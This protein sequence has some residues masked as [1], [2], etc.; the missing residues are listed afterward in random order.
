MIHIS[1]IRFKNYKSF[2]RYTITL[3]KFNV[4]VGPNNSGKSTIIGSLKI[5]S[6]GIRKAKSRTPIKIKGPEGIDTLGYEIDLKNV[7]V[8]TENIFYNYDDS[9]PAIITFNLSN[10]NYLKLF[11]F[12]P[13]FCY[14]V[15]ETSQAII[16]GPSDF[17]RHFDIEIGYVP[18]LGPVEHK[19]RKFLKEAARLALLSYTASRNFRNIWFH[20]P[21]N[22]Q[23]FRNLVQETWPGMDILPPEEDFSQEHTTLNMFCPEERIPREIF[24]AGFGFQVWCQMLT[25][26]IQSR[27]A[28]I[29]LIDEPD[30]YLHSDLQRQLIGILKSLG[31]DILIATHSTEMISEADINEV[32]VINKNLTSAQRIKNIAQLQGI[33]NILGSNLNPILTQIAKTKKVLFVEGKD[34]SIIAKIARKLGYERVATRSSFAVVPVEGFNPQRLYAFKQGIESTIGTAIV[35]GVIFDRDYR[36]EDEVGDELAQLEEVNDFAHIH[37]SKELEN[38]LLI[39]A[40]IQKAIQYKTVEI[41]NRINKKI[42]FSEDVNDL[43]DRISGDLKNKTFSQLQAKQYD[44]L[45]KKN[46][47][48][49]SST[50]TEQILNRF[51]QNWQN[52]KTRIKILP[53]KEVLS[54][55]NEYLQ[56]QYKISISI[57]EI[58]NSATKE[59]L[60]PDLQDLIKK[61]NTFILKRIKN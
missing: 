53:G 58:I 43:L 24:W 11:F 48:I 5:L 41:E 51:E 61:I 28:S 55:L 22:F 57:S 10:K 32:L 15:C 39:P 7:P 12:E 27:Q 16:R 33:F 30:I 56:S 17:K 34:F 2:R 50:I 52:I 29:F 23:E 40:A 14:M 38:Y 1:S 13:G 31:P 26:I 44:Y 18:V 4:L 3:N 19:E 21:D 25:Y 42:D 6:E 9:E 20:Y 8:A 36:C 59:M 46:P 45:K 35:S 37:N 54:R 60:A 47:T 49:D